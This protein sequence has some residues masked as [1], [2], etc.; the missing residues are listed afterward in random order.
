M[1]FKGDHPCL[2]MMHIIAYAPAIF[3]AVLLAGVIIHINIPM[4]FI[5]PLFGW[6]A[7]A[8]L[9]T[10]CPALIVWAQKYRRTLY[11][12]VTDRTCFNFNVGPYRYSR[13]PVYVSL[14]ILMIGVA[15]VINSLA[16]I[17]LTAIVVIKFSFFIIP[18]EEHELEKHCGGVY[19]DY[20][21]SVRMWM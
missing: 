6:I 2:S 17:I 10:L 5:H 11:V 16:I 19:K 13:H 14:V 21:K 1:T 18:E 7:G 9:L 20:K 4:P 15:L 3:F 8:L 12:P